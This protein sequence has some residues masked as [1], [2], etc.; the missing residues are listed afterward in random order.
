MKKKKE[1][2][3]FVLFVYA[4]YVVFSLNVSSLSWNSSVVPVPMAIDVVVNLTYADRA[5]AN[6]LDTDLH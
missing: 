1:K 5:I 2:R 6:D 3:C 4:L